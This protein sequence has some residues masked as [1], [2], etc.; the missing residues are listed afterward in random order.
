MFSRESRLA[1]I[2]TNQQRLRRED[3]ELM[4]SSDFFE[5]NENIYLPA[6]F[7]GS[8]RWVSEQI[9]NSLAIA[10][11]YGNPT[12]FMTMTCNPEWPEIQC[13]LRPGQD[14]TDVPVVLFV[15]SSEIDASAPDP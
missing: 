5:P 3:A 9:S 15:S 14:Y 13:Q 2:R 6:S 12:F 7:L 1:Y 8:K 4:G 10:A 11:C